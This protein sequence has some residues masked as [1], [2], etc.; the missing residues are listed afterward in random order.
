[1]AGTTQATPTESTYDIGCRDV[2]LYGDERYINQPGNEPS[3]QTDEFM[4]EYYRGYYECGG[5]F[6]AEIGLESEQPSEPFYTLQPS[7]LDPRP[8]H[9]SRRGIYWL[10]IATTL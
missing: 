3:S 4:K 1:M 2:K 7:E 10:D 5:S 8:T 6:P 9:T